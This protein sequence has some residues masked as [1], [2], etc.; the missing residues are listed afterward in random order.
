VVSES[1]LE[2]NVAL[3]FRSLGS[4]VGFYWREM[5]PLDYQ[6]FSAN[7]PARIV[8]DLGVEY[9]IV[10]RRGAGTVQAGRADSTF[11]VATDHAYEGE[12]PDELPGDEFL[13]LYKPIS[14]PA[15]SFW[16]AR[17]ARKG[18]S[19]ST[20]GIQLLLILIIGVLGILIYQRLGR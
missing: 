4:A 10:A 17:D 12:I 15:E 3:F 8:G 18:G 11:K 14:D 5:T 7:I 19:V 20:L 9:Y 13:E 1:P 2:L 6:L 16:V